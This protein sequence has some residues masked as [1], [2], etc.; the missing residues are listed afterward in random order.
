VQA[1]AHG[2]FAQRRVVRAGARE[3]L[4]QIAE[5]VWGRDAQVDREP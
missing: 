4:E 1:L 3:V 5:L 2:G